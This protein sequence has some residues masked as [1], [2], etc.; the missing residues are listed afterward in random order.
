MP[1]LEPHSSKL[2][3]DRMKDSR[4]RET[5]EVRELL[6]VTRGRIMRDICRVS[7]KIAA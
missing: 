6:S 5:R 3:E 1:V 7:W 4:G 2:F